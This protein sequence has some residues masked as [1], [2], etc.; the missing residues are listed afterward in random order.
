[1][2]YDEELA[3]RIRAVLGGQPGVTEKRMFGG[4]A[5]LV[6]A[7][8]A[9][10]A[11]SHGALM[12]RVDPSRADELVARPHVG[13]VAMRGRPMRGWLDVA[14]AALGTDDVL[15]EWVDVGVGY[16]RGLPAKARR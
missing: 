6:D 14:P 10:A 11:S 12:V 5:F 15:R 8:M 7:K 13:H 4:L 16:A 9:V 1:M 3:E 2:A